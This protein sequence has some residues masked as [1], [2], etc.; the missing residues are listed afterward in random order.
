MPVR[1]AKLAAT[2]RRH[3]YVLVARCPSNLR[4][5]VFKSTVQGL[6]FMFQALRVRKSFVS[7]FELGMVSW[8][9][10][11][12]PKLHRSYYIDCSRKAPGSKPSS[13]VRCCGVELYG[14]QGLSGKLRKH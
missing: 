5:P 3:H 8:L 7:I 10:V 13:G 1:N 2:T 4:A 9:R 14:R 6:G 11:L 12:N